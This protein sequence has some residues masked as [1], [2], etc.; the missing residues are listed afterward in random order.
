[1][2]AT[3]SKYGLNPEDLVI[4]LAQNLVEK[5]QFAFFELGLSFLNQGDIPVHVS[6]KKISEDLVSL[7]IKHRKSRDC[8]KVSIMHAAEVSKQADLHHKKKGLAED[9]QVLEFCFGS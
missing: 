7:M 9:L 4:Y 6:V 8:R 1:M 3:S 5:D 2:L